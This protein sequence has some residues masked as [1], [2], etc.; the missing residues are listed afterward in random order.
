MNMNMTATLAAP[1]ADPPPGAEDSLNTQG[2][3]P[4]E[5]REDTGGPIAYAGGKERCESGRIGLTAN[6]LTWGTGSEGSN[7]SLSAGW[8]GNS[9]SHGVPGFAVSRFSG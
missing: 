4:S 3:W 7:P 1:A 8:L 2:I 9:C 5:R 6:E